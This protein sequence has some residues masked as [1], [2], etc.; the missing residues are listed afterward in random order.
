M[1][2]HRLLYCKYV[3]DV[4]SKEMFMNQSKGVMGIVF[5]Q[6]RKVFL[7]EIKWNKGWQDWRQEREGRKKGKAG[8]SL[9]HWGSLR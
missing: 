6:S 5:N 4:K 9:K 7:K 2:E 3:N 1:F 8:D